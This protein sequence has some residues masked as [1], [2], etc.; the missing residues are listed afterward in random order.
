MPT[1][2]NRTQLAIGGLAIIAAGLGLFF[3]QRSGVVSPSSGTTTAV[4]GWAL[5]S[6]GNSIDGDAYAAN[7][8]FPFPGQNNRL[9][10]AVT[11]TIKTKDIKV[12][13]ES[14][15]N[16]VENGHLK[17]DPFVTTTWNAR[18]HPAGRFKNGDG[19]PEALGD[20]FSLDG[21]DNVISWTGI[22]VMAKD[23]YG[24][25]TAPRG[26]GSFVPGGEA[27]LREAEDRVG[28]GNYLHTRLPLVIEVQNSGGT[29]QITI[30]KDDAAINQVIEKCTT[31]DMPTKADITA[32]P[33]SAAPDQQE[34]QPADQVD[35]PTAPK[36]DDTNGTPATDQKSAEH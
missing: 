19:Q 20:L 25:N 27:K 32:G 12:S 29:E 36:P 7:K 35:I 9:D 17:G 4:E 26:D 31:H 8:T 28:A 11:C 10:V 24:N 21:Y 23:D 3:L 2:S 16:T 18:E 5:N 30:P 6:V 34:Q 15:G 22:Q 13:I 33:T 14:Y 1:M